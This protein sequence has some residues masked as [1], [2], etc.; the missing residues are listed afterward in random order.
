M[1]P[2]LIERKSS[3]LIFENHCKY[4]EYVADTISAKLEKPV[5]NVATQLW[6]N[7]Q[8]SIKVKYIK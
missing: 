6:V 8:T 1:R 2:R 4:C 3:W 7:V 5:E